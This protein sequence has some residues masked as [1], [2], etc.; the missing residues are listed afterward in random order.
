[1]HAIM[2]PEIGEVTGRPAARGLYT[3]IRAIGN[4]FAWM[5]GMVPVWIVY[6]MFT[7]GFDSEEGWGWIVALA[8][9][10]GVIALFMAIFYGLARILPGSMF[11]P[12]DWFITMAKASAKNDSSGALAAAKPLVAL[13]AE[14]PQEHVFVAMAH[15]VLAESEPTGEHWREA[16]EHLSTSANLGLDSPNLRIE[17]ARAM[18]GAGDHDGAIALLQAQEQEPGIG[19]ELWFAKAIAFL[20]KDDKESARA[21]LEHLKTIA[22]RWPDEAAQIRANVDSGLTE[23][24][25][26]TIP[27]IT[28]TTA[29]GAASGTTSGVTPAPLIEGDTAQW[30]EKHGEEEDG[31]RKVYAT[32]SAN[33]SEREK[34]VTVIRAGGVGERGMKAGMLAINENRHQNA[35][36]TLTLIVMTAFFAW[37]AVFM[38]ASAAVALA[39]NAFDP[40]FM[41]R[42]IGFEG[43]GQFVSIIIAIFAAV[44]AIALFNE[45]LKF[46]K[47]L[48]GHFPAQAKT[49]MVNLASIVA[50]VFGAW[51]VWSAWINTAEGHHA[52]LVREGYIAPSGQADAAIHV[53]GLVWD[54][55]PADRAQ[56]EPVPPAYVDEMR[57]QLS[58]QLSGVGRSLDSL[59]LYA[60]P[61]ERGMLVFALVRSDIDLTIEG[62]EEERRLTH[63]DALARGQISYVQELRIDSIAGKPAVLEAV[64]GADGRMGRTTKILLGPRGYVEYTLIIRDA[65]DFSQWETFYLKALQ[66]VRVEGPE[67]GE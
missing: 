65:A 35:V 46:R 38:L 11:T 10:I 42:D 45:Q 56:L 61:D 32:L 4:F 23:I 64:V 6:K 25:S 12:G 21:T 31:W 3:A 26:G 33:E 39:E 43:V 50:L 19:A 2:L 53:G 60:L 14:T 67:P 30:L 52:L 59:D 17:R 22:D 58:M 20:R 63:E 7:G 29:A 5:L 44:G 36:G 1:M 34:I 28:P 27:G 51:F 49:T 48:G 9:T 24:A 66:T 18:D 13:Q 55:T 62:L 41:D 54:L 15:E 47:L 8:I 40:G 16:L 57:S 37:A